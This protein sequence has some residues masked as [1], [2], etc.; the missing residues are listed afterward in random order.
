MY[1]WIY[2]DYTK[3]CKTVKNIVEKYKLKIYHALKPKCHVSD[4]LRG[5]VRVL[6]LG[7]GIVAQRQAN[8]PRASI[9]VIRFAPVGRRVY[10]ST[11][12][13]VLHTRDQRVVDNG[14]SGGEERI[15]LHVVSTRVATLGWSR[16]YK[17]S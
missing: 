13:D 4:T 5:P 3:L 2:W 8:Q 9:P 12:R 14:G 6:T 15:T 10:R 7:G 17:S 11:V 16:N 1:Q